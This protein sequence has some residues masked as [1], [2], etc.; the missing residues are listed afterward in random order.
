MTRSGPNGV[1][2]RGCAARQAAALAHGRPREREVVVISCEVGDDF[3]ALL[4]R[5]IER[6]GRAREVR[7]LV[8]GPTQQIREYGRTKTMTETKAAGR[9]LAALLRA[10]IVLSRSSVETGDQTFHAKRLS[11]EA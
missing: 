4:E 1:L 6:S 2:D 10:G 8:A 9:W 5:A 3:A 11:Q 7:Q